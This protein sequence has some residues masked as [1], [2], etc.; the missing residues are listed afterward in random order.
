MRLREEYDST[1]VNFKVI[2]IKP[3]RNIMIGDPDYF[4]ELNNEELNPGSIDKKYKKTLQEMTLD[5]KTSCCKKGVVVLAEIEESLYENKP[6]PKYRSIY[7][8]VALS[9]ATDIER[10]LRDFKVYTSD[11]LYKNSVKSSHHLACDCAKFEIC[12]DGRFDEVHTGSDGYYGYA[13]ELKQYY[14]FNVGFVFDEDLFSFEDVEK[15]ATY[16]FE[17]D[18]KTLKNE[19]LMTRLTNDLKENIEET[20]TLDSALEK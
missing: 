2:P 8:E 9:C 14:G 17:V 7:M 15:L 18:K 16:W 4:E 20:K 10:S 5:T 1:I 12:I 11:K 13:N 19:E 6:E 3:F